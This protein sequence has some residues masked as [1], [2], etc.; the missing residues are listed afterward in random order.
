MYKVLLLILS[1]FLSYLLYG[2]NYFQ[3]EVNYKI[4][5]QLNDSTN[6]LFGSIQMQYINN[7][8]DTL[9]FIYMHLWPNAYKNTQTAFAKQRLLLRDTEFYYSKEEDKGYID[10]LLFSTNNTPLELA[11]TK[12]QDVK[13][14]HLNKN[15]LPNDT[16]VISSPFYLKI[17]KSFSRLGHSGNS[18]QITQWYPKPAVYDELGWHPMPYL[19]MGE[20]YSEFG[21][22]D[23][24]INLPDN[25]VVAA[26]GNLQNIDEAK[27]IQQMASSGLALANSDS[28]KT[29]TLRYIEHNIHDFAWFADKNFRVVSDSLQ[30]DTSSRFIICNAFYLPENYEKWQYAADYVKQSVAHY[31]KLLGNYPYNVCTAVD[32]TFS[33]GGGMEYP[34]ITI[35]SAGSSAYELFRVILHEVG[36]NWFYGILASNERDFPWIDEGFNSY[37]EERFFS[38]KMPNLSLVSN[39]IDASH[40]W[41]LE[42]LPKRYENILAY[43]YLKKNASSQA[44]N[45]S[46]TQYSPENYVIM[47]Y[48][49]PV[50]ALSHLEKHL[51]TLVFDS[52]MQKFY[53]E[54]KFQHVS[55]NDFQSFFAQHSTKNTDWVFNDAIGSDKTLDYAIV[56]QKGDSVLIKNT[57]QINAALLISQGDSNMVYDGFYDKKWISIPNDSAEII[58]DK[59]YYTNDL[60]RNNNLYRPNKLFSRIDPLKIRMISVL[61]MPHERELGIFPAIGYNHTQKLMLGAIF[62]NGL[63]PQKRF[64]YQ[65]MPLFAPF[66]YDDFNTAFAGTLNMQWNISVNSS[67][68]QQISIYSNTRKYGLSVNSTDMSWYSQQTGIKFIIPKNETHLQTRFSFFINHH[69]NGI[70]EYGFQHFLNIGA[71]FNKNSILNPVDGGIYADYTPGGIKA[72]IEGH[73]TM[74]YSKKKGLH[75]RLFAGKFIYTPENYN[76]NYNFRL[77]GNTGL[78]DYLYSTP[79]TNRGADIRTNPELFWSHQFINNEGGFSS[80]TT[81]GQTTK[82]LVSLNLY[83]DLPIPFIKLFANMGVWS[84]NINDANTQTSTSEIHFAGEAG[85][86]IEILKNICSIYL[87]VIVSENIASTNDMYFKNNYWQRI[88]FTLYLNRLNILDYRDQTQLLY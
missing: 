66:K 32:G 42:K 85:F 25:Y 52:L 59:N 70:P 10:S 19:D 46:S 83:S 54:H 14:L 88:R 79:F 48:S 16:I 69:Y 24:S 80:Y 22:F 23:V 45:L 35:I 29:K 12:H 31:S 57:G 33:S 28:S 72:W 81:L 58:I 7:S 37:Y 36:H 3:Q 50:T 78:Q 55:P 82:W 4:E 47:S 67:S 76:G 49:K 26:T 1:I 2:Q 74:P 34:T 44:S 56:K 68:V 41:G 73:Y 30:I 6:S 5:V 86:Q 43:E 65:I 64:E 87:P 38:R 27:R 21:S 40:F 8:P 61:D 18:Y 39:F 71:Q 15:L 63:I 9:K 11:P 13:L 75:V 60:Y 84:I 62:Y 53:S 51:G 17:P 77:S 20:F